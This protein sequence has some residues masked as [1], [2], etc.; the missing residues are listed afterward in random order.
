MLENNSRTYGA[1]RA[2]RGKGQRIVPRGS[3]GFVGG[4]GLRRRNPWT[5]INPLVVRNR[6]SIEAAA[7]ARRLQTVH[8]ENGHESQ[9]PS[10]KRRKYRVRIIRVINGKDALWGWAFRRI[11]ETTCGSLMS[12]PGIKMATN[13]KK[14]RVSS[15]FG[16]G[17]LFLCG[18]HPLEGAFNGD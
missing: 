4:V 1:G 5:T 6:P 9:T 13:Y 2:V 16:F 15:G 7:W 3:V 18:I 12:Q 14:A 11:R 8:S 17:R 10:M